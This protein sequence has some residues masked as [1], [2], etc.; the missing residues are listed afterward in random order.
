M[1]II[2]RTLFTRVLQPFHGRRQHHT[3]QLL[4]FV[5]VLFESV[6][7]T[8]RK[9]EIMAYVT[10]ITRRKSRRKLAKEKKCTFKGFEFL[11]RDVC[12]FFHVPDVFPATDV[13]IVFCLGSHGNTLWPAT[14]PG[15]CCLG[16]MYYTQEEKNEE[17]SL[18]TPPKW[19]HLSNPFLFPKTVVACNLTT[20]QRNRH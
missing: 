5:R 17:Y 15:R 11:T 16:N 1:L 14:T 2:T 18:K 8:V 3:Y 9:T 12:Y 6:V 20:E 10:N 13:G 19:G 7:D 4:F